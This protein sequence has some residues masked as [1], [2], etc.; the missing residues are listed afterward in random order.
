M[1][2]EVKN[3]TDAVKLINE[4]FPNAIVVNPHVLETINKTQEKHLDKE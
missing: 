3:K 1:K 4:I 2:E